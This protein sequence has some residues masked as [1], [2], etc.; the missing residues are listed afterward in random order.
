MRDVLITATESDCAT[1]AKTAQPHIFERVKAN[2]ISN[3]GFTAS[4]G[5]MFFEEQSG[6]KI[7]CS[8]S[9][10]SFASWVG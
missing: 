6:V 8:T 3:V 4:G 1:K 5:T 9:T 2:E 10:A 7:V